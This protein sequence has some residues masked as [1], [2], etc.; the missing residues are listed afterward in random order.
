MH[1]A[2]EAERREESYLN[3][4]ST[5][6]PQGNQ[7]ILLLTLFYFGTNLPVGLLTEK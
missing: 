3:I 6:Q 5:T 2:I 4:N 7:T 1:L